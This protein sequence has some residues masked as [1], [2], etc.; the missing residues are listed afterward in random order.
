MFNQ[1]EI[2][3]WENERT[4]YAKELVKNHKDPRKEKLKDFRKGIKSVHFNKEIK[5]IRKSDYRNYRTQMKRLLRS[6]KYELLRGYK[7]TSGWLTW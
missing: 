6:G 3:A 1:E 2:T 7:R 4:G 5:E